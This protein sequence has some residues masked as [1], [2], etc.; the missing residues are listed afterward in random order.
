MIQRFG[1]QCQRNTSVWRPRYYHSQHDHRIFTNTWSTLKK[2]TPTTAA[3]TPSSSPPEIEPLSARPPES[4]KVDS[5]SHFYQ[6]KILLPYLKQTIHAN[7]LRQYI[8]FGQHI[9]AA[10]LTTSANWVRNELLVRLAHRIRDFQQL[11]FIIGTNPN[12]EW[13]YRLYW[14]AFETLRKTPAIKTAEDNDQFCALLENLLEDGQQVLP[15]MAMG[16]SECASYYTPH[17]NILDRFLNRMMKSRISRRLLAEQHL[18][19][20]KAYTGSVKEKQVLESLSHRYSN[21]NGNNKHKQNNQVGIFHT[22]CS[23]KAMLNQ[24]Q[25]LVN[26]Q[27]PSSTRLPP[28]DIEIQGQDDITFAY[29]PDQLEHILYELLH[30]ATQYTLRQHQQQQHND[31]DLPHIRITISANDTDVFFRFSDQAGG[32]SLP[33]YGRLWSYQERANSGDFTDFRHVPQMPVTLAERFRQQQQHHTIND[34]GNRQGED[35][36]ETASSDSSSASSSSA[37]AAAATATNQ[38]WEQPRSLGIGLI[39]S[40]VYAEYWGGELQIIS[41]DNYGTDAYVRIP[42]NG[43]MTENIGN[44]PTGAQQQQQQQQ[45]RHH[46]HSQAPQHHIRKEATPMNVVHGKTTTEKTAKTNNHHHLTKH[47]EQQAQ[48]QKGWSLSSIISS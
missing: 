24:V 10:R 45:R 23:A 36:T 37:A 48:N 43:L 40:R 39:L 35:E 18:A 38:Q 32:I 1:R 14:G 26:K 9:N 21:N 2:S 17:D 28:V 20:T 3:A 30:N 13:P 33:Q 4:T 11:P 22:D 16:V 8:I 42:R 46:H 47:A 12:I 25:S 29:I 5:P 34:I 6:N 7:T 27:Y 19:L 31:K 15:R 44:E 41:M